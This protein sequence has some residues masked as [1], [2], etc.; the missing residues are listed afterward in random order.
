MLQGGGLE[1]ALPDVPTP[2]PVNV[3][4]EGV[5]PAV[6]ETSAQ[7]ATLAWLS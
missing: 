3:S 2:A 1:A 5:S 4:P 6:G 7:R